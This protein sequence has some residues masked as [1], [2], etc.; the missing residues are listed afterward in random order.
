MQALAENQ[1]NATHQDGSSILHSRR[2][3]RHQSIGG[4]SSDR[5]VENG[6][7]WRP[8]VVRLPAQTLQ[9]VP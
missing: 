9:L 7:R 3:L 1:R 5:S 2:Y 4:E 6:D 8:P